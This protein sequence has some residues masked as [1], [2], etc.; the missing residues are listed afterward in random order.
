SILNYLICAVRYNYISV[1]VS[2]LFCF[3]LTYILTF[4]WESAPI[5]L[6]EIKPLQLSENIYLNH[7][8][9]ILMMIFDLND[10]KYIIPINFFGAVVLVL[11]KLFNVFIIFG[12]LWKLLKTKLS[13]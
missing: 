9:N 6:F 1:F 7:L 4:T 2:L 13:N 11:L 8:A 12:Y 3:L 10:D 5:H